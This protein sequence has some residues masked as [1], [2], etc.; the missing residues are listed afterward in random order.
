MTEPGGGGGET[1]SSAQKR[2]RRPEPSAT[3]RALGLLTRREHSRLELSRKLVIRGVE[4]VDAQAVIDKLAAAGWQDDKRFAESLVRSRAA[5]GYGPAY[6]RAELGTHALA[7]D[8]VA[9]ALESYEGDWAENACALVTRRFP[10]ALTGDRD[11]RRKAIDF[12]LRRG[13]PIEQA[14]AALNHD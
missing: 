7:S 2:R 6:I 1:S 3:Q 4:A 9:A 10:E 5:S 14:R 11:V 8:A 13:F 12:L